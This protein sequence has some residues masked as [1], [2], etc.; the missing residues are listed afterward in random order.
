M[1]THVPAEWLALDAREEERFA[2]KVGT[3]DENGCHPWTAS[4]RSGGYGQFALQREGRFLAAYA[5]RISWVRAHGPFD[6]ELMIDH[7]CSKTG[8][9]NVEH[10]RL[11]TPA[12]NSQ[13]RRGPASNNRSSGVRGVTWS[14]PSSKWNAGVVVGGRRH[15]VGLF[16][17]LG[18][19]AAAVLDARLKLHTHSDPQHRA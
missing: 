1:K 15:H 8:C 13:H 5:H 10:L 4:T 19:A 3:T 2:A 17:D 12:Q 18:E 16:D 9:V 14:V 7:L 6:P 11:V